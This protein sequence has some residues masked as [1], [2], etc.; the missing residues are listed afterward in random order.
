LSVALLLC[1]SS[2]GSGDDDEKSASPISP[3]NSFVGVK[4]GQERDDNGLKMK[5]LWC[6]PG[7]FTMGSPKDE[8]GRGDGEDQVEVTLSRGFW[9]G[10]YEVT[11]KQWTQ[12]VAS[13]PWKDQWGR[14]GPDYPAGWTSWEEANYFCRL[15]TE[16]IVQSRALPWSAMRPVFETLIKSAPDD[17]TREESLFAAGEACHQWVYS[18]SGIHLNHPS[19]GKTSGN[20]SAALEANPKFHQT[21]VQQFPGSP[22]RPYAEVRAADCLRRNATFQEPRVWKPV[23]VAYE[24]IKTVPGTYPWIWQNLATA[25]LLVNIGEFAQAAERYRLVAEAAPS[26]TEKTFAVISQGSCYESAGDKN[27][28]RRCLDTANSLPHLNWLRWNEHNDWC[29]VRSRF[30]PVQGG[31]FPGDSRELI[32]TALERLNAKP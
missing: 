9:L 14:A 31:Q 12:I 5:F 29:P 11:Q 21:L 19:Y 3:A 1:L 8:E 28:A 7:S 10:K 2:N 30:D 32:K 20:T 15:L 22:L 27:G 16:R 24:K 23:I 13:E 18:S 17:I 4:I 6:P 25:S 26:S